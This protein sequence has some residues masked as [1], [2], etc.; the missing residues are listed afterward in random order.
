MAFGTH[1]S[2]TGL[3]CWE[4]TFGFALLLMDD[5]RYCLL[6]LED[7]DEDLLGA[8]VQVEGKHLADSVLGVET[9]TPLGVRIAKA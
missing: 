2:L 9:L 8:M 6:H 4:A 1:Q 7:L 3:L 5:S